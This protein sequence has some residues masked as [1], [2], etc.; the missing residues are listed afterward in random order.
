MSENN[1]TTG[2]DGSRLTGAQLRILLAIDAWNSPGGKFTPIGGLPMRQT[3]T[4]YVPWFVVEAEVQRLV[5]DEPFRRTV[6]ELT[7]NG[8]IESGTFPGG[9]DPGAYESPM[10]DG[11]RFRVEPCAHADGVEV[12]DLRASEVIIEVPQDCSEYEAV[13][14]TEKGRAVIDGRRTWS[15]TF[16]DANGVRHIVGVDEERGVLIV[17]GQQVRFHAASMQWEAIRTLVES[18]PDT[19]ALG[20]SVKTDDT[21]GV[22]GVIYDLKRTL[23]VRGCGWLAEAV[24]CDHG[25]GY[26]LAVTLRLPG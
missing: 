17:D 6:G 2:G 21:R 10:T 9:L 15:K 23:R 7:R 16:R 13:R 19:V 12:E 5:G 18:A 1:H 26:Y 14:L 20:S 3:F 24:K 22:S 25:F 4:E 8:Y 11:A